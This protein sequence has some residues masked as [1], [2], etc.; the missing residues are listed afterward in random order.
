MLTR[1]ATGAG[2]DLAVAGIAN[3]DLH[4]FFLQPGSDLG[5]ANDSNHRTMLRQR[6]FQRFRADAAT[7]CTKN[8]PWSHQAC[9]FK[10]E[11]NA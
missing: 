8:E 5:I 9:S 2:G 1:C 10:D 7:T 6:E 11:D 3:K 4:T